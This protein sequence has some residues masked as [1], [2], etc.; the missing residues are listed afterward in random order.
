MKTDRN[1]LAASRCCWHTENPRAICQHIYN[2]RIETEKTIRGEKRVWKRHG[3]NHLLDCLAAAYRPS[4]EPSTSRASESTCHQLPSM[5]SRLNPRRS[6]MPRKAIP[7][8]GTTRRPRAA[9][10]D[11]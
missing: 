8:A 7:K 5:T 4:L 2:E 1:N 6:L 3:A 9:G 11:R 10:Y